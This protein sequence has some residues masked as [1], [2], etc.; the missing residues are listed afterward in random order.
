MTLGA[1]TH[2]KGQ[3]IPLLRLLKRISLEGAVNVLSATPTSRSKECRCPPISS[4]SQQ[5]PSELGLHPPLRGPGGSE[6]HPGN[7]H[8]KEQGWLAIA[9]AV[10]QR[11]LLLLPDWPTLPEFVRLKSA[12]RGRHRPLGG[13]LECEAP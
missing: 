5:N 1:V 12:P 11:R 8:K 6:S 7:L 2:I 13:E 4:F 10:E 3:K 9:L